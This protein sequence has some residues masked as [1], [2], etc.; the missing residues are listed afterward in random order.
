MDELNIGKKLQTFRNMRNMNIRELSQKTNVTPS[1]LSQL[2]R[3]LVNP[4]INTLKAIAKA[5]DVPL[6]RFFKDDE[7]T[8]D[9]VVRANKRKTIGLP[10]QQDVI[11]DL[12]TPDVSGNIEFCIMHIPPFSNSSETA[13]T[14]K[15]EE[16]A[17][18]AEGKVDILIG[19]TLYTLDTGDSIRIPSFTE[20][21]W[22]NNTNEHIKIV[23]AISPPCF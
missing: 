16:V 3:D 17:Y 7:E 6:F 22:K 1:M 2:E 15:S 10:E 19:T 12:L 9:I 13:L 14:H 5:L 21:I 20:H 8:K 23:F 11:Y 18:V 4:S